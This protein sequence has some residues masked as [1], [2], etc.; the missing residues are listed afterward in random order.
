MRAYFEATR[1]VLV[2]GAVSGFVAA[3]GS[4]SASELKRVSGG[5]NS[6]NPG[7]RGTGGQPMNLLTFQGGVPAGGTTA[8]FSTGGV[9]TGGTGLGKTGGAADKT[10]GA[11]DKTGGVAAKVGGAAAKTGGAPPVPTGGRATGGTSTQPTGGSTSDPGCSLALATKPC[12]AGSCTFSDAASCIQGRCDC[13]SGAWV[14]SSITAC[15]QCPSMYEATCGQ[16][17]DGNATGCQC[18]CN[19]GP[20][21]VAC[22]CGGGA[23]QC[24]QCGD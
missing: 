9:P 1:R 8:H 11:A 14:C 3:C 22:A 24:G 18:R 15:T 5:G 21:Y 10:G 4:D 19:N 2:W 13:V 6:T 16:H 20:N 7:G 23:W 12:G 17:C